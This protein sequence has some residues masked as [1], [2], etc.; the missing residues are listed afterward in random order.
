M[1]LRFSFHPLVATL[2]SFSLSPQAWVTATLVF[3]SADCCARSSPSQSP[4]MPEHGPDQVS[5][6]TASY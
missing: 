1:T 5:R 4:F 3:Y 6:S 2:C